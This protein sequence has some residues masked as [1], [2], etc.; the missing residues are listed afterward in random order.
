MVQRQLCMYWGVYPL[1]AKRTAST[2]EMLA[3]AIAAAK[4]HGFIK[5]G[6]LVVMTAGAA[7]SLPGTTNLIKVQVIERVLTRGEGIGDHAVYGQVRR[8]AAPLPSAADIHPS[9]ILVVQSSG[10]AFV[11]LAQKA[12]G[13]VA[14]EGGMTSHA[15]SMAL[16]LGLIAVIGAQDAWSVLQDGQTVTLDPVHGVVYEGQVRV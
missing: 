2:D 11:P 3:G 9:D 6:D 13:V 4:A 12:A 8:I 16:E 7:G 10:K 14:V 1:L 5:P 15:A